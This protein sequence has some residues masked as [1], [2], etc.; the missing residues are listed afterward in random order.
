V[1]GAS[2]TI[3]VASG[4]GGTGKTTVATSLALA[5]PIDNVML[6][7]CD[8]EAPNAHLYLKPIFDST[9]QAT[10]PT[11][12]LIPDRCDACGVCA[13][14]CRFHAVVCIG[15]ETL[16]FP[17]LCH[18]CGSCVMQCPRKALKEVEREIG[19]IDGG[20]AT[21]GVR[22]A[23]GR[24]NVGEPMPVP[25]IRQLKSWNYAQG[26]EVE[27]RDAPPGTS[28][29]VVET[30]RGADVVLLITEP[31][32]FGL[33]DLRLGVELVRK[34]DLPMGVVINRADQ[35][36]KSEVH[37]FCE[38]NQVPVLLEIPFRREI[39]STLAAGKPLVQAFPEFRSEFVA[40]YQALVQLSVDKRNGRSTETIKL[41]TV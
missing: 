3:A 37:E 19:Q 23:Q 31:T 17:E 41:S 7:D 8:V 9:R 14:A 18:G 10:I 34:M 30:L 40:L 28:C 24:L 21:A 15:G 6:L 25:V 36:S 22:L 13:Q 11:P 27:I 2:L 39:A 32:P 4:K 1:K 20:G 33:H 35:N 16:I 12:V 26:A 29:S 5:C 38:A